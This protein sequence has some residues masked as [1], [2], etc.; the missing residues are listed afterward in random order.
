M[1]TSIEKQLQ[2]EEESM[3][4][5]I[6]RYRE[7][8]LPW[9]EKDKRGSSE[10][11]LPPGQV[12]LKRVIDPVAEGI[13]KWFD[14]ATKGKA[15]RQ[16]HLAKVIEGL[17]MDAVAFLVS[18]RVINSLSLRETI[19]K[20]S[21]GIAQWVID[22]RNFNEFRKAAPGY[23]HVMAQSLKT[24][25]SSRHKGAVIRNAMDKA[26]VIKVDLSLGDRTKLGAILIDVFISTTG[27]AQIT[28][29]SVR[30]NKTVN[31]VSGTPEVMEWLEQAHARCE[32]LSPVHLPMVSMPQKWT[33]P[34]DGGY[35]NKELLP[36]QLV[37]TRNQ[38]YLEELSYWE[39]PQVYNA[40]N[41]LQ[42]T[43][44]KINTG[45][46]EVLQ[47]VW[48]KGGSL[49]GLPV[50]DNR[51]LPTKPLDIAT[52][53][54]ARKA[55]K[56]DAVLVHVSNQKLQ[57]KRVSTAQKIWLGE[58]FAQEEAIYFPH[59]LDWRGRIYPVPNLVNPQGDD[60]G[61]ALLHFAEGKPLGEGGG[62][63]LAV[64]I[65]NLFGVDKVSLDERVA[66]VQENSFEICMSAVEPLEYQFWATADKPYQALAA[67]IEWNG[68]QQ[69]G[70]SFIS[71][72]PIAQDGSNNG[73]Q[74]FGMMMRD[75]PTGEAVNLIPAD[76]PQDIYQRVADVVSVRV[77]EDA[78]KGDEQAVLWI[79]KV[80]R[81][82]TKRPV[83]TLPY[84][85]TKFGMRDQVL[86]EIRKSAEKGKEIIPSD[87]A[88]EA[89]KYLA[90]VIYDSIGE[91]VNAAR[92]AMDWLQDTARVVAADE[93]PVRWTTPCGFPVVQEY[94]KSLVKEVWTTI[95]G[96]RLS[97]RV[98][99]E[100]PKLDKKRQALGIAPNVVHSLDASH[101]MSTVNLCSQAG[102]T[103]FAMIHDSYAVH[104]CDVEVLGDFLR[105]AFVIQYSGDLLG[106]FREQLL[107][108]LPPNLSS[109]IRPTPIRGN[110]DPAVVLESQYFFA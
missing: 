54:E 32:L 106:D 73:C 71:R 78:A 40:V 8:R 45:V 98:N 21:Q 13:S 17:D 36:L 82:I 75:V 60:T 5:G 33:T 57:G 72:L 63:W 1:M 83:M 46:L 64:H 19:Q 86:E 90:A 62:Y 99:D 22:E 84:G 80:T 87:N 103:S 107:Q 56:R 59:V 38:N 76:K 61:K 34:H 3:G 41:V 81:S 44:W 20:V 94:R 104:A 39:M 67:C 68:F 28:R 6:K 24:S 10:S 70:D 42:Q 30:R 48:A 2:L 88:R 35:Y 102:L 9:N 77:E 65:A 91:V 47:A 18:K 37:K 27:M 25:S 109:D 66:W 110:L 89:C 51:P 43:P 95:G 105:R 53:E 7:Q 97:M 74:H 11:E 79:G 23:A 92:E 16:A 96:A 52:N 49:G 100:G 29:Q 108:Q 15:V 31:I 12:Q 101:L 14:K 58:K 26:G 55:W 85:A 69:E 50:R 93:L 4:L